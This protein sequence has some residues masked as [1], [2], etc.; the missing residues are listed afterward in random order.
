MGWSF[1]SWEEAKDDFAPELGVFERY[2]GA[3]CYQG[4][5]LRRNR[6]GIGIRGNGLG[7]KGILC[8]VGRVWKSN[9]LGMKKLKKK[10]CEKYLLCP[11]NMN[12]K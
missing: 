9:S 12:M 3:V 4:M 8:L 5:E 2:I 11:Y 1:K 6:I 10:I 7:M